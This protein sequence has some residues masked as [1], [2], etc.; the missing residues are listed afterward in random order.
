MSSHENEPTPPEGLP[1]EVAAELP[2]LTPDELR[3]TIIYAQELLQF[4]DETASP[5]EPGPNEEILR[6]TKRDGYTEVVKRT[7]CAEDCGDCPHGPYLYHVKEETRP[8][9]GTKVHWMFLG[10]VY[11]DEE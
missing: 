4:H 6:A 10:E 11:P 9:G 2:Q 8:E 3:N 7:T 1:D 5:V